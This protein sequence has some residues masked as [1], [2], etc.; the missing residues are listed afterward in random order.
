MNMIR[1]FIFDVLRQMMLQPIM[2]IQICRNQKHSKPKITENR[3]RK[4]LFIEQKY[5]VISFFW[6]QDYSIFLFYFK[7][8]NSVISLNIKF[9][10]ITFVTSHIDKISF[11]KIQILSFNSFKTPS[12]SGLESR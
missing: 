12:N 5:L 10:H 6:L 11:I 7:F 1:R 4:A 9:N 2:E 8:Y 3:I